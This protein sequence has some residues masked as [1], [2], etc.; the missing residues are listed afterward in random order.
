LEGL[1]VVFSVLFLPGNIPMEATGDQDLLSLARQAGFLI[2]S[3]CGG[4]GTCD[5]CQMSLVSG[6][7]VDARDPL[8]AFNLGPQG[9]FA[10]CQ[11]YPRSDVVIAVPPES[12]IG[13]P[14][15][16]A[17]D[18]SPLLE[19]PFPAPAIYQNIQTKLPPPTLQD[20]C[21]DADRVI[22]ELRKHFAHDIFLSETVLAALPDQLRAF[23]WEVSLHLLDVDGRLNLVSASG[24]AHPCYGWAVD[25]GTTS[26]AVGLVEIPTGAVL[27]LAT[28]ANPQIAWGADVIARILAC[29]TKGALESL[30]RVVRERIASLQNALLAKNQADAED[31]L[32][33]AVTGNTTMLHLYHGINPTHIRKGPYIPAFTA[34]PPLTARQRRMIC[35][36]SA[37]LFTCPS[38][39][40]Y[41]GGDITA[42]AVAAGVDLSDETILF[43]DLGTNGEVVLGNREW[44]LCASTSAGPCFE[45]GGI[46][47]GMR[48]EKG[49]IDAVAWD[50]D[51]QKLIPHILGTQ[52]ARGICG[53]G[54]FETIAVLFKQGVIDR[55]GRLNCDFP[56][57]KESPQKELCYEIVPA[58]GSSS[59]EAIFLTETDIKSFIYSK[60]AVYAGIETL[61]KEIEM[62]WEA[63]DRVLIAGSLGTSLDLPA[64]ICLG[65]L[66]DLDR[67][68]FR[69]LG[70]TSL[71]GARLYL[72]SQSV[73]ERINSL[74]ARVTCLELSHA[75]GFMDAYNAALFLPHTDLSRFPSVSAG[76]QRR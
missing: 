18:Y 65:L 42:G 13:E 32:A 54:L 36:P 40:S 56:G 50:A 1:S 35:S 21:S 74:A 76:G 22:R 6:Q 24:A 12:R 15:S 43:I 30:T 19:Q 38:V 64:A 44:A 14:V 27:D 37:L 57:V 26:L 2:D 4:Q 72:L 52:A 51:G 20:S 5:R 55:S 41:V 39:A 48:A 45:G 60:A 8:Q 46:T 70:N 34:Y 69:A 47:C 3:Q 16:S 28:S 63:V 31:V 9:R 29:D 23:G 59:G 25:I 11:A 66:P 49:A 67:R 62:D 10:S 71:A 58:A 33:A 53:S 73:Q 7:L 75:P 68:K 61:L 17:A